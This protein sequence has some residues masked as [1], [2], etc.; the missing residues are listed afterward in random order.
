MIPIF[1]RDY[2]TKEPPIEQRFGH[3]CAILCFGNNDV[4][5]RRLSFLLGDPCEI[6]KP[7]HATDVL[8]GEIRIYIY[9]YMHMCTNIKDILFY[10]AYIIDF[11]NNVNYIWCTI[12]LISKSR[13]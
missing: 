8:L 1:S 5:H 12:H 9:L 13:M 3:C 4:F 6:N 7:L 2:A 10:I 11:D